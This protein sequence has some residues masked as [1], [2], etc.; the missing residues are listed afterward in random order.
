VYFEGVLQTIAMS[1]RG[2]FAIIKIAIALGL[3]V[4]AGPVCFF[5][6]SS[7]LGVRGQVTAALERCAEAQALLGTPMHYSPAGYACG[8]CR[9]GNPDG[10]YVNA[11]YAWATVPVYGPKGWGR[12]KY[13]VEKQGEIWSLA[14]ARLTVGD[15]SVDVAR[16]VSAPP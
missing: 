10:G 13:A 3:V 15:R 6:Q 1:K 8:N 9:V 14:W 7:C 2:W 4:I 16:C 12:Y 11:G 5:A